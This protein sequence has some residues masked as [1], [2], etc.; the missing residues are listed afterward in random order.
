M[1]EK[2]KIGM[3]YKNK[4]RRN[5]RQNRNIKVERMEEQKR[6]KKRRRDQIGGRH[7]L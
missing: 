5:R 6:Q 2:W 4:G 3:K 7:I 1:M